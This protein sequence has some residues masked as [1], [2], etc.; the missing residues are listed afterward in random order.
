MDDELTPEEKFAAEDPDTM[1]ARDLVQGLAVDAII[2]KLVRLDWSPQA[3]HAKISQ[4][5]EDLSRFHESPKSRQELVKQAKTSF[6]AGLIL[7]LLGALTTA[8]SFLGALA[9]AMPFVI[10][11]FGLFFGGLLLAGRGWARW[12]LYRMD[13]LPFGSSGYRGRDCTSEDASGSQ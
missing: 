6:V 3:A 1:I 8:W 7:A 4:V 2:T 11:A 5:Q 10:L 13:S 9:G 12:R